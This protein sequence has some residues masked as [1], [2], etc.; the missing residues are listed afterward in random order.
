MSVPFAGSF[1]VEKYLN[2]DD[3]MPKNCLKVTCPNPKCARV[4][5]PFL[6][7]KTKKLSSGASGYFETTDYYVRHQAT[8]RCGQVYEFKT[9]VCV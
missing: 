2:E 6:S 3:E 5:T 4:N 1:D 9:Y 8:C 7:P